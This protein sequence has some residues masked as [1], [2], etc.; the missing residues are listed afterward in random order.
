MQSIIRRF[1]MKLIIIFQ[2][3]P[4]TLSTHSKSMTHIFSLEIETMPKNRQWDEIYHHTY[5]SPESPR[6]DHLSGDSY[7]SQEPLGFD[8]EKTKQLSS[9]TMKETSDQEPSATKVDH[10]QYY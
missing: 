6:E 5:H 4:T 8:L 9:E 7:Y 2:V 1:V 10:D 3:Q